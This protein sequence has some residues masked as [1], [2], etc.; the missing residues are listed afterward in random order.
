MIGRPTVQPNCHC[1]VRDY[2]YD[3]LA[4]LLRWDRPPGLSSARGARP[5]RAGVP[6][7]L[8][9]ALLPTQASE[10]RRFGLRKV[11]DR[12]DRPGGLSHYGWVL[13]GAAWDIGD[14]SPALSSASIP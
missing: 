11:Y 9:P 6:S 7:D 4:S 8:S 5:R 10:A 14:T 1:S 3:V 12:E 2:L 13:P